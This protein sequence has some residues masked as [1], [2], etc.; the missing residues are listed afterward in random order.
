MADRIIRAEY[1]RRRG[2]TRAAVTKAVDT[3]RIS[4]GDDGLLDPEVADAEWDANTNPDQALRNKGAGAAPAIDPAAKRWQDA[5][6]RREE[7]LADLAELDLQERRGELIHKG[8]VR[9]S[10]RAKVVQVRESL[11]SMA[12][13]L[14]PL[15]AA[16][17]DIAK[18]R[19]L[20]RGELR[21]ALSELA[22]GVDEGH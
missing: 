1:A 5:R 20:I 15:L 2:V 9:K 3:G 13:R 10:L 4:I 18:V 19:A 17:A 11:D 8:S 22:R 7:R 12:D 6:A 16:E 21:H 14:A